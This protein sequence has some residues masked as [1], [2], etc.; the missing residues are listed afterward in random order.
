MGLIFYSRRNEDASHPPPG[1]NPQSDQKTELIITH[2][3]VDPWMIVVIV[4]GILIIVTLAMF[5]CVHYIKSRRRRPA[6]FQRVKEM[7]SIHSQKRRLGLVERQTVGDPER[8]MM[9]RKSLASRVS[10]TSSEPISQVSSVSSQEY[11]LSDPLES[12]GEITSL[13]EDWKEW[14]ARLQSERR[15]SNPR[16]VGL[17]QHP[18]FAPY[19][20]VPQPTRMPSPA[21][22]GPA[23]YRHI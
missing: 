17:D 19:L 23:V 16:G 14:E 22:G 15:T 2:V 7:S 11:H 21:R 9:I 12:Q 3:A 1:S 5:M 6:G 10:L 18:A 13:R 20:S 8:D 4:V